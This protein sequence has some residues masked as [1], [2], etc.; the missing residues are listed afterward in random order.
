MAWI[1]ATTAGATAAAA[2][3]AAA[4]KQQKEEE[5]MTHYTEEELAGGWEFKIV[6]SGGSN[7]FKNPQTLQRVM[8]EQALAGW[9]MVEKFSDS[10]IR[11]K[12]PTSA[13]ER[14]HLLEPGI[15]PYRT[16]YGTSEAQ[17]AITILLIAFGIFGLVVTLAILAA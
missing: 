11:F 12:R 14:D 16:H 10:R 13:R 9:D 7:Y 2:A 15:D 8:D 3:A 6:R 5:E 17:I 1:P 4:K